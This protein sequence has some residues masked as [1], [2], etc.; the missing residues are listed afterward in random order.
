MVFYWESDDGAEE[1]VSE[2]TG[3]EAHADEEHKDT[4]HADEELHYTHADDSHGDGHSAA[5]EMLVH[6]TY[7]EICEYSLLFAIYLLLHLILLL[8][9]FVY[10]LC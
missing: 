6:V 7:E 9:S 5:H 4:A 8:Q 2:T 3:E 10:T 1:A